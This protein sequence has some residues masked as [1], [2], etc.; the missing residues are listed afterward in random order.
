MIEEDKRWGEE[1]ALSVTLPSGERFAVPN[2]LYILGTMNTAD[3]SISLIDTAL[4]RRFDFVEMIPDLQKIADPTLRTVFE[5]LNQSLAQ[6][7]DGTDLLVGHAYFIGKEA[8]DLCQIM[9]RSIIPLLYEYFYDNGRKVENQLKNAVADLDVTIV[10]NPFG[11]M[12]LI[13]KEQ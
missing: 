3:K 2:N 12:K 6:E 8:A 1:N 5:K 13:K 4:R 9:N 10:K 11:R 7:L